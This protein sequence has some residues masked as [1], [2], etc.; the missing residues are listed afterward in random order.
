MAA[1]TVPLGEGFVDGAQQW[2][3]PSG[4]GAVG[5]VHGRQR[6]GPV[7]ALEFM[8]AVGPNLKLEAGRQAPSEVGNCP[9][10]GVRGG[11]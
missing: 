3:Q 7:T 1:L 4:D 11:T 10:S 6:A 5:L 8:Q 9:R 2:S